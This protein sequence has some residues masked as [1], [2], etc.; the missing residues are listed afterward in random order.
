MGRAESHDVPRSGKLGF[1]QGGAALAD[2]LEE[3][4][5]LF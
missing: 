3:G 5:I 4:R 1:A 2:F